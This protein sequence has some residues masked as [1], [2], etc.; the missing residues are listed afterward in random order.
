MGLF[1]KSI[2]EK[3]LELALYWI[4]EDKPV[5]DKFLIFYRVCQFDL[6][7]EFESDS[8]E[9]CLAKYKDKPIY[10]KD[11]RNVK[12][13]LKAIYLVMMDISFFIAKRDKLITHEEYSY[14]WNGINDE[15]K[16]KDPYVKKLIKIY[17]EI[18]DNSKPLIPQLL[19]E[20][21]FRNKL[22]NS[23]H[24]LQKWS[25]FSRDVF[26]REIQNVLKKELNWNFKWEP[27]EN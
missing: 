2:K 11:Y 1:G 5:K 17:Q 21:S 26:R 3:L 27:D 6:Y 7:H 13:H 20:E 14:I 24:A 8:E 10:P 18:S 15:L 25:Y 23:L 19:S 16:E 4:D 22:D 9:K 12:S